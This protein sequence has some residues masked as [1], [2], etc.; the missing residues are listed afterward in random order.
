[1][2]SQTWALL[3][4]A[5]RELNAKKLF[6][7][8]LVLSS[9]FVI[10]MACLGN[11]AKGLTILVWHIDL[12]FASTNLIS[13]PIFYKLLFIE[14]GVKVW[15]T[16]AATALALISTAGI[17]PEFIGSG[18]IE[19]ALSKPI[20]RLRLFL[21][22]YFTGLLFVG[23]QVAVFS[24]GAFL[25]LG[26]RGGEWSWR[27]FLGIPIVLI[28]FS[29]LYCV[30][31]LIGLLTRS[32]IAALL[33]T[34]LFWLLIFLINVTETGILL[35]F[36][37]RYDQAAALQTGR[38]AERATELETLRK[39]RAELD[40]PKPEPPADLD[41]QR[42]TLDSKI[43][44]KTETYESR[45][46][47]LASTK[48]TQRKLTIAHSILFATKTVLPKTTETT[49]LLTRWLITKEEADRLLPEPPEAQ[50]S[51]FAEAEKDIRVPERDIQ[52]EIQRVLRGR[53]VGWVAGT[54]LV[55]E[56]VILIF[57]GWVFCRRDF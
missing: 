47:K 14:A 43:A 10:A 44:A 29:Y 57:A 8:V 41:K 26:I 13:R 52:K 50:R 3:I 55:F 46:K 16:W 19:L 53:S 39:Q 42:S 5:Y 4:D 20:G 1:M 56:C 49:E 32:T 45:E 9:L 2:I 21:T 33:L 23:L 24:A 15:L 11:D 35:Q 54:S 12:P 36:K 27:L 48:D 25:V 40:E 22:K 31:A 7:I 30:C 18:S 37:V 28:F 38:L 6:W 51:P 17:I 34:I